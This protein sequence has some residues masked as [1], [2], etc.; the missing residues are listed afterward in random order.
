[1]DSLVVFPLL[2]LLVRVSTAGGSPAGPLT[3]TFTGPNFIS[4]PGKALL[5]QPQKTPGWGLGV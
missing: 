5:D 2:E 1:M 3:G 4:A